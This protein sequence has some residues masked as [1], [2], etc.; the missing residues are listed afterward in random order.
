MARC[1]FF[2]TLIFDTYQTLEKEPIMSTQEIVIERYGDPHCLMLRDRPTTQPEPGEVAIAVRYSGINFADVQ[3]RLGLYPD[4]PKRP[5]VP[6]YEVSGVVAALGQGVTRF[7]VGDE[8]V[9]GTI[10]GGYASRVNVP[11]EHAFP[12][13]QKLDLAQSAAIPAC[14]FTSHLALFEMGRVRAGDRVLI[15]CAT[16]GVGTLAVQMARRVGAD[17]VGLTTTPSKKA[18]VEALGATAYTREE[19]AANPGLRDFDLILNASGG[20]H[21]KRQ[22]ERLGYTGRIVCIG[23]NSGVKDGRRNLLRVAGAVLSTPMVPVLGLMN[24]NVGV[25]GLN[26]LH[27]LANPRWV[28]RL[29]QKLETIED[30]DLR[31]HVDRVFPSTEAAAA[32]LFLQTKQAKG[33]VLLQWQ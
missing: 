16:G 20:S 14:F 10:F 9:A 19:F 33:K 12:K 3:M 15:E 30:M 7:S 29:T 32:H 6:G 27:I 26:A 4:A 13:P 23:L 22:M 1:S 17:V 31:P 8:V 28:A 5:F 21:I 11:Q 18:Y 25:Y 2:C 24:R